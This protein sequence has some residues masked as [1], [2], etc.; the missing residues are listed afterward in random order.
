[1]T[2]KELII[3]IIIPLISALLGGGLTVL[4]V[5][6]SIKHEN[7]KRRDE[8]VKAKKPLFCLI[9]PTQDYNYKNTVQYDFINEELNS[10]GWIV[11]MFKNTDNSILVLDNIKVDNN[12]YHPSNGTLVDKNLIFY[13]YIHVDINTIVDTGTFIIMTVK[14]TLGNQY[15]YRLGFNNSECRYIDM[16]EEYNR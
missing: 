7:K 6:I 11:A 15:K 9:D 1:M 13:T 4:G 2:Q 12:I 8:E 10:K 5:L 14:D 16:M 3:Y